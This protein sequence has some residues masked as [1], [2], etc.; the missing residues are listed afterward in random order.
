MGA[1]VTPQAGVSVLQQLANQHTGAN[2]APTPQGTP[3]QPQQNPV[4]NNMNAQ[5]INTSS[6]PQTT[7]IPAAPP[8]AGQATRT[9]GS[10]TQMPQQPQ[11]SSG[12]K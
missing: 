2:Q 4:P 3:M 6:Q 8:M 12:G 10:P 9:F 11:G 7:Q 1:G 5:P